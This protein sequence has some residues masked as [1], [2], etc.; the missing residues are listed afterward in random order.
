[1]LFPYARKAVSINLKKV[2]QMPANVCVSTVNRSGRNWPNPVYSFYLPV[3]MSRNHPVSYQTVPSTLTALQGLG[4]E[5]G[6][7]SNF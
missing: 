3:S 7:A 1:M 2:P 5:E 4:E 6:E